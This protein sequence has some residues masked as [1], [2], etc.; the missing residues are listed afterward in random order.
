[1]VGRNGT[2]LTWDDFRLDPAAYRLERAGV[3][4]PLEPKA[5]DVLALL[6]SDPGRLFTKQDIFDAVWADTAVTDHALTRVIAQLRRALGDQSRDGRYIETV[7]TRGYRWIGPVTPVAAPHRDD[8]RTS[9]PASSL[10][11]AEP[12]G[13]SSVTP[14]T[15]RRGAGLFVW[16][17]VSLAGLV[18]MGTLG[19][20]V[21]RNVGTLSTASAWSSPGNGQ[22]PGRTGSGGVRPVWPVQITTHPGLDLNPAISPSGDA[23]AFASDRSGP[24]EIYVR[25]MADGGVE[26]PLTSDGGHNV[27]PAWSPDGSQLAY[28]SSGRGGIWVMPARGGTP[29]QIVPEGSNPA[30]SPDGRTLAYQTDEHADITPSAFGAQAGS[31]IWLVDADGGHPRPLTTDGTPL[32]GHASPA[33]SPD[34]RYVAFTTFDGGHDNGAWIVS[35][36]DGRTTRL[37]ESPRLYE[38]VFTPDGSALFASGGEALIYRVPFDSARGRAA[39]P[40]EPLPVPGV[41]GVRGLSMAA[42]GSR[43]AFGGL[44][45]NSQIWAQPI[46]PD[47]SARGEAYAL[48]RDTSRRNWM[49]AISPD[50]NRVAYMSTRRGDPP[51]VWLMNIDGSGKTQL[52][53]DQ[54][55]D[56][57]PTWYPDAR[58][59]AYF[60]FRD[61]ASGLWAIDTVTRRETQVLDPEGQQGDV[62]LD[63]RVA[64]IELAPSMTQAAFSIVSKPFARRRVYVSPLGRYAPRAVSEAQS[65]VGYPVWSPDESSLAVELKDGSSTQAAVIEVATGAMRRLTNERGQTWVRSW[66]PDGRRIAVAAL[67]AGRWSLRWIDVATGAQGDMLPPG[68]P[69]VYVRY[70]E[71]SSRGDLVVFERG[72]LRGNVWTLPLR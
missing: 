5:F 11:S 68:P 37:T 35:V 43:L 29:R 66:S 17:G 31:T 64:E 59:I 58:R 18:A 38:L 69:H 39:G 53:A 10:P 1:M 72:E 71:W 48:T 9:V 27:Q 45:L 15:A 67:R 26:L 12:Q 47:G 4:V 52:T 13:P 46:A 23:V 24:L 33:W 21:S 16:L 61:E 57:K 65:W 36:A 6:L 22:A 42:D 40:V 56:G 28:H 63:G 25:P 14:A 51:N 44:A 62:R 55:A 3:P 70:P 50:G 2:V 34:G 7:P 41:P 8:A 30:W 20:L 60:S 19:W 49:A 32:G 54:F